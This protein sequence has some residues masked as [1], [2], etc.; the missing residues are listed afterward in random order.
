MVSPVTASAAPVTSASCSF[1]TP[2]TGTYASTLCWFDLSNYNATTAAVAP[3][4][5]MSVALPGGYSISFNLSVT[6]G[7]VHAVAF[8][9]FSG[10]YLGNSGHYTG[11]AGKPALYQTTSGHTTTAS[12]SGIRVVNAWCRWRSMTRRSVR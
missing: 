2:G 1:A 3:G 4:Q 11:V 8:P 6:G 9:T 7:P 5:S 12:L 10:A